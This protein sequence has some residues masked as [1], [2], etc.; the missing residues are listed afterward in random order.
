MKGLKAILILTLVLVVSVIGLTAC[1]NSGANA[2]DNSAEKATVEALPSTAQEDYL[3]LDPK[4]S[5]DGLIGN[6]V[7]VNE[8]ERFTNITKTETGYE[9]E[10]NEGKCSATFA[11][12]ILKVKV[13]DSETAEV[14]I[15]KETGHLLAIYQGVTSEFSKK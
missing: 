4:A 1:G 9:Y 2:T 12:G 15:D 3:G 5:A 13:S 10:D 7:E 6:W 11:D 14:Y 8:S